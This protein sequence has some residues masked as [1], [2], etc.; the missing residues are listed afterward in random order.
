MQLWC[1]H[2]PWD[3]TRFY[4]VLYQ[5]GA[6]TYAEDKKTVVLDSP[7]AVE[8]TEFVW[9]LAFEYR[10]APALPAVPSMWKGEVS[11][12]LDGIWSLKPAQENREKGMVNLQVAR[13]DSIYG[14]ARK[15]IRV[16]THE[17]TIPKQKNEDPE[18]L[19]AAKAFVRFVSDNNIIWAEHGQLPVRRDAIGSSRFAQLSDH[20]I[21]AD[22]SFV[23]LPSPPWGYGWGA[24]DTLLKRV[25][26]PGRKDHMAAEGAVQLAAE[27]LRNEVKT[28][29]DNLSK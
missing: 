8:A 26:D 19:E 22:Q 3:P 15:G 25:A 16:G 23:Y 14:S 6:N 7:E 2:L 11:M 29:Y 1:T 17:M 12:F 18:R 5:Y 24:L 10:V 13:A 28:Y 21:I 9:K 27:T 4:N 20:L